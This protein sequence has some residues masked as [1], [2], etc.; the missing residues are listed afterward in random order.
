M[1]VGLIVVGPEKMPELARSLAKGVLE[2]KK[3]A[4]ALK[5]SL[6]AEDATLDKGTGPDDRLAT[7]YQHLPDAAK[8]PPPTTDAAMA[9]AT[10]EIPELP[11]Q[12][13]PAEPD[14]KEREEDPRQ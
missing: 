10:E 3:A 11:A 8:A 7:A 2:L 5:E 14:L 6:H 9:T 13:S 1:A 12:Q 4:N